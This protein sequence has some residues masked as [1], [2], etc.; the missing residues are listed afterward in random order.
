MLLGSVR[1][2]R[3]AFAIESFMYVMRQA[4]ADGS[5]ILFDPLTLAYY[6]LEAV[7]DNSYAL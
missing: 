3:R 7:Y 5:V 2:S 6:L 1:K 4:K